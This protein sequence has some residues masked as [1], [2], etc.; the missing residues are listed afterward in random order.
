MERRTRP[1]LLSREGAFAF[2]DLRTMVAGQILNINEQGLSFRY[3]AS[4]SQAKTSCCVTIIVRDWNFRSKIPC[5]TVW[6]HAEPQELSFGPF[7][8]RYCGLRFCNLT[9]EQ[10]S[11]L[12]H[13]MDRY[14]KSEYQSTR[15]PSA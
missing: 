15:K 9:Q 2:L 1:R 8:V 14:T 4:E 10:Q 7:S 3:V 11:D 6:D 5:E 13:F 12:V